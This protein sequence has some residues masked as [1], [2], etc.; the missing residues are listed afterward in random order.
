LAKS[1]S[2]ACG[3]TC[4]CV[5][6]CVV[7]CY[8]VLCVGHT[9][10]IDTRQKGKC[11]H[12]LTDKSIDRSTNQPTNQPSVHPS[13]QATHVHPPPPPQRTEH[14]HPLAPADI[15]LLQIPALLPNHLFFF[16]FFLILNV[17]KRVEKEG[18]RGDRHGLARDRVSLPTRLFPQ[19]IAIQTCLFPINCHPVNKTPSHITLPT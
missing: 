9:P 5:G 18:P 14:A 17:L 1:C 8:V 3:V 19:P 12:R 16:F 10:H 2:M 13:T 15:E 7:L 11:T 6:V 4:V